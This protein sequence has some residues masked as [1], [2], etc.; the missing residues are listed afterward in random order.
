MSLHKRLEALEARTQAQQGYTVPHRV[1]RY[2]HILENAHRRARG[3]EPLPDLEY[4]KEDYEDDLK[5]LH[6]HIPAMRADPG[7]QTE[8]SRTFLDSWER[9]VQERTERK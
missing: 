1:E 2:F 5:T 9:N 8:E 4:T 7:W 3:L 6:E